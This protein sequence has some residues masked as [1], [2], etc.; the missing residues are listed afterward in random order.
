MV[1]KYIEALTNKPYNYK[2]EQ[3]DKDDEERYTYDCGD[4]LLLDIHIRKASMFWPGI[5]DGEKVMR[6]DF[7]VLAKNMANALGKDFNIVKMDIGVPDSKYAAGDEAASPE[8]EDIFPPLLPET[9]QVQ[10]KKEVKPSTKQTQ[11]T[12]TEQAVS[13]TGATRTFDFH[14]TDRQIAAMKQTVAKG[15][16]QAQFEMF[17]YL[18]T[19]YKLDPFL[20]EIF[21]I[22]GNMNT[23]LTSRDGYLKIAQNHKDFDGIRSMAV[24]SNDDFEIDLET[25]T[26]KHK[27]GKGVRGP[28]I[29][30]WAIVYRKGR[31]PCIAFADLEEYMGTSIPWK[32][33]TSAMICKCAQAI[34]LK[35]Q[36]S[37]NGLV[38]QEEMDVEAPE[39]LD[40]EFV[41]KELLDE[42][43]QD[44][45]WEEVTED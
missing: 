35:Q 22:A 26:I 9:P 19:M 7:P 32:K 37:I 8:S 14:F 20:K 33:Y 41:S 28:I 12:V 34:A 15:A 29:G 16:S 5:K 42:K 4:G 10:S 31:R 13:T 11:L 38:T 2:I 3:V 18:A 36:F 17:I 6:K 1:H 27:F 30:A 39:I 40:P 24:R 43:I 21:F 25:D 45:E 44:A 23:V